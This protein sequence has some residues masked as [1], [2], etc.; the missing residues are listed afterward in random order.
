MR[1]KAKKN[2]VVAVSGGFDPIHLGHLR[3][4]KE[5]KKLG[6]KLVVIINSDGW[7]R[8]KKGT[9]FMT[10]NER[11]EIIKEFDC[12][13]D[14]HIH[15]SVKPHVSEAL[16]KVKPDVFANGGDRKN[17]LDVPETAVC[18]ELGIEM[19]FGVGGRKVRSSSNMLESYC[20]TILRKSSISEGLAK[21]DKLK[22]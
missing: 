14:V 6:G 15:N 1:K 5:A 19:V 18:E 7:L 10:A 11:A 17:A 22:K 12:V 20:E 4:F 16:R 9:Y 21:R 2:K 13:D 8:R 3:M